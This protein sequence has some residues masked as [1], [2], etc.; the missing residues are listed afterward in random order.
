MAEEKLPKV[1]DKFAILSRAYLGRDRKERI[2]GVMYVTSVRGG[3]ISLG[4]EN[5]PDPKAKRTWRVWDKNGGL[6]TTNHYDFTHAEPWTEEHVKRVRRQNLEYAVSRDFEQHKKEGFERF[7]DKALM[8]LF[9][10]LYGPLHPEKSDAVVAE[11]E[12]PQ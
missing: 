7:D 5:K 9:K 6:H 12:V 10:T 4:R 1:G 3:L 11:E 2:D 8:T